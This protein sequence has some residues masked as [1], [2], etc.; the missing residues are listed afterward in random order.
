VPIPEI[1]IAAL[2]DLH[3][4]GAAVIDVR[5]PDEYEDAHVP[6]ATLIPLPEV[7]DRVA[8]FP[9]DRRVYLICAVG[10]RSMRAGEFLAA[11]GL[12]VVNIAGGT[13]EWVAAGHPT[14]S[15]PTA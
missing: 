10:G 15:G 1:D 14:N 2:A 3:A 5:N 8:E 11:Q 6:G 7:P 12:D 13:K 9:T 4:Q